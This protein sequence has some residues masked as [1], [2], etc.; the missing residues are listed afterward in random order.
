MENPATL[1]SPRESKKLAPGGREKIKKSIIKWSS[2]NETAYSY[3]MEVCNAHKRASTT[4][5]LYEGESV[6]ELMKQL[7][8]RFLRRNTIQSE[9]AKF[10]TLAILS[11]ES[12]AEFIDRL[13]SQAK[14]LK[15]W[16]FHQLK[17]KK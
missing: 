7:A 8:D 15:L 11:N 4:A 16:V 3:L 17:L 9:I 6:N 5:S 10:N 12:G 1:I 14:T 13:D 2:R